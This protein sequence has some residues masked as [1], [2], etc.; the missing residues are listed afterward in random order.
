MIHLSASESSVL[1][2]LQ[3]L[4][5]T[6]AGTRLLL[7]LG[8][9]RLLGGYAAEDYWFAS[10][11]PLKATPQQDR[12]WDHSCNRETSD[13]SQALGKDLNLSQARAQHESRESDQVSST[14]GQAQRTIVEEDHSERDRR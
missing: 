6:D 9:F 11:I 2:A 14:T 10:S 3:E 13:A 5:E 7:K 4:A 8:A 1:A 12:S